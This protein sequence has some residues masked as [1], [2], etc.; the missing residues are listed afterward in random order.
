MP[1][2]P[3]ILVSQTGLTPKNFTVTDDSTG[4]DVLIVARQIYVQDAFGN[5]LT[6]NGTINYDVWALADSSVTFTFLTED[7]AVN[8][9]VNWVNVSGGAVATYNNNYPLSEIGKQFFYYL[10]QLQGLKPGVY[11]DTNYVLNLAMYWVNIVAGDHAVN[12]GNDISAAQNCYLRETQM[13]LKQN[14]YF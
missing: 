5:Y 3:A 11:M 6:G 8:I 7:I 14:L 2:T 13:R 10:L 4:S 12:F 9:L 1:L